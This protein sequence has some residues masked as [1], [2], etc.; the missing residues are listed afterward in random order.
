MDERAL[1]VASPSLVYLETIFTGYLRDKK[2]NLPLRSSPVTFNRRCSGFVVNSAG[3]ALTNGLCVKPAAD[4]ARQHALLSLGRTLIVEKSLDPKS[5]DEYVRTNLKTTVF[6]GIDATAP[7]EAKLYGQLNVATGNLSERPAIPAEV[8][9]VRGGDEGNMAIVKLSQNNL[10]AVEVSP[11]ATVATGSSVLVIGYGTSDADHRTGAYTAQS[12]SVQI[13]GVTNRGSAPLYR[14][15]GDVG[16][17]SHG[18]MAVDTGGR[19]VGMLEGDQ[20]LPDKANRAVAQVPTIT[21]LLDAA[22]VENT[23]GPSDRLY[24]RGLDAYFAGRYSEAETELAQVAREVPTNLSAGTYRQYAVDREKINGGS[25]SSPPVWLTALLGALGGALVVGLCA[26]VVILL[27]RRARSR[28]LAAA[29]TPPHAGYP[30]R[31]VSGPPVSGPPVAGPPVLAAPSYEPDHAPW[32]GPEP[33]LT[34]TAVTDPAYG[35]SPA[36]PVADGAGP[37]DASGQTHAGRPPATGTG[38]PAWPDVETWPDDPHWPN[39]E[40]S[41][42]QSDG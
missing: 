25:S 15:N 10:P 20:G 36:L 19:I 42:G 4:T 26:V 23:L 17:Y 29:L 9:L 31:Q 24:R 1:A 16:L 22:K 41:P 27:R 40:R 6:T 35:R 38:E 33:D 5:L 37:A 3:Y 8:E 39:L 30:F 28:E 21:A 34:S 11:S 7:P 18:G 13:T 12:K 14:I 32:I 2:T